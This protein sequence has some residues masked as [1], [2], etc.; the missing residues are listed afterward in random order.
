MERFKFDPGETPQ[1]RFLGDI[2]APFP[3]FVHAD[4]EAGPN[5]PVSEACK[6]GD[7]D[8]CDQAIPQCWCH[9]HPIEGFFS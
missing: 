7:H 6:I 5:R 9:H 2:P 3:V 8:K 1:V 4:H